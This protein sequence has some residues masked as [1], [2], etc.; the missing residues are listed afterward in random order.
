LPGA[1]VPSWGVAVRASERTSA[2][3]ERALRNSTPPVLARVEDDTVILDL[4]TVAPAHDETL[5]S[6]IAELA[7]NKYSR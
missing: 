3:V 1:E 5:A 6:L 2:E 4:R 7:R